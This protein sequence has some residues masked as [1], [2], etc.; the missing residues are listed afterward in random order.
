M[1]EE[2]QLHSQMSN[3]S[4]MKYLL[5]AECLLRVNAFSRI[6]KKTKNLTSQHLLH[7][8]NQKKTQNMSVTE[9]ELFSQTECSNWSA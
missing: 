1:R 2:Q 3:L 7:I 8:E 9:S 5:C 4:E 6:K